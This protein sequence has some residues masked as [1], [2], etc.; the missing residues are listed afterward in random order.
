MKMK[1]IETLFIHAYFPGRGF[2]PKGRNILLKES[3]KRFR[4]YTLCF[5][6]SIKLSESELSDVLFEEK[7]VSSK[8]RGRL[9]AHKLNGMRFRYYGKD[10]LFR[11]IE[12]DLC[13]KN[14]GLLRG[15]NFYEISSKRIS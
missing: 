11:K 1:D 15:E 10:I 2:G 3:I 7:I 13:F 4:T 12:K 8:E 6:S 5:S 9:L 14:I